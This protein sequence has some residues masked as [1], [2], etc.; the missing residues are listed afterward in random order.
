MFSTR[1]QEAI[2]LGRLFALRGERISRHDLAAS[3]DLGNADLEQCLKSYV[4][5]GY[6]I[7]FHPQGEVSLG[8][9]EDIWSAEEII[10]RL[11]LKTKW[12]P[13][14]LSETGSTND[15]AREQARRGVREGF[16]VAATHQTQGRGR[17][18]RTWESPPQGGLYVS[19]LLRPDLRVTEAGRLTLYSSLA[20]RD[21]VETVTGLRP[22]LKW[23]NDL[24][25]HGRK[26]AGLL[27]ET[28]RQGD[29]FAW[30]I[31]GL[32]L[33]VRQQAEDFSPAVRGLATSLALVTG[34]DYRRADLLVALLEALTRRLLQPYPQVREDW[35]ASS[36]TL[37]QR[38]TLTTAQG[39]KHGQ[40]VGLDESGALLLRRDA[41]EIEAISAGDLQAV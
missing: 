21:A 35:A 26:L 40:A 31:V 30:A 25:L 11:G 16:V 15:V 23:P 4:Q 7:Q 28:E 29:H 24:F 18:G 17:L 33:N 41:G 27:V 34:R 14:L 8:E 10:G 9:V 32:G 36:L 6:P 1:Q 19:I 5:A 2:L 20:A 3:A 12:D 22:Q 37:G 38:V 13:L 39:V